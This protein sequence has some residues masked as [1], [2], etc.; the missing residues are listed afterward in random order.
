V[1]V[2][3]LASRLQAVEL[4]L[5]R[6]VA[7]LDGLEARPGLGPDAGA[8]EAGTRSVAG[9]AGESA[10]PGA[11]ARTTGER[12]PTDSL[13][14]VRLA[15]RTILALAGAYLIRALAD[16][17]WLSP[18]AGVAAGF[19]YALAFTLL[20]H[21]A[22][23]RA[24][25]AS[26]AFHGLAGALMV[27]PLLVETTVRH[28]WLAPRPAL[29]AVIVAFAAGHAVALRHR[30]S[31]L[32]WLGTGLATATT[33][34]LLVATRELLVATA[35][36][37]VVAALV[38]GSAARHIWPGLRWLAAL[39]SDAAVLALAF[40][41]G[42]A[43]GLPEEYPPLA[44]TAAVSVS[45]ALPAL[46]L[47]GIAIATLRHRRL[48]GPFEV[49]QAAAAVA[50]GFGGGARILGAH[51]GSGMP[52]NMTAV[53]LG[54]AAYLAAFAF[55]ERRTGQGANFYFYSTAGGLL[56]LAGSARLLPDASLL[57]SGLA[58]AA[59]ELGRRFDRQTL[60][61]HA[62]AYLLAAALDSRLLQLGVRHALG[63]ALARVTLPDASAWLSLA[64][65]MIAYVLLAPSRPG[66][67]PSTRAALPRLGVAALA[68]VGIVGVLAPLAAVA[69]GLDAS[70]PA[71]AVVRTGVLA[72]LALALAE[73]SR[74][75]GLRELAWLVVAVLA[76]GGVK[77]VTEDMP[78]GHAAALSASFVL[79]GAALT[80]APR[81]ARA[82]R[83]AGP[84][85]TGGEA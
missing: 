29:G 6:V 24:Q 40:V 74:R 16:S 56:T 46:Y 59:A 23:R 27:Y 71:L 47:A 76:L 11:P 78:A 7:R 36:A 15:G 30:I 39:A 85:P 82:G 31:F 63:R 80:L 57:L 3:D 77:L 26:A 21:R 62:A 81:L 41:A 18:S 44:P 35:T 4:E 68:A 25:R 43:E 5:R 79:Y 20:A 33:A 66:A 54:A 9:A 69:A 53:A 64:A 52:L 28:G 34:V 45:L 60:R 38:E 83:D 10:D 8:A 61:Y 84:H 13:E 73:A 49:T 51:G 67:F 12:G 37:L 70:G 75:W 22:A 72:T 14:G 32:A 55:V 1:S 42:R 48:V 65:T 2:E 58:L 50:L 19:S 17:G